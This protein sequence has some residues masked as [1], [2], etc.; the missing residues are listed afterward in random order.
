M[1]VPMRLKERQSINAY[2]AMKA[3]LSTAVHHRSSPAIDT[4]AIP[5]LGT[6]VG[7]MP[8][9]VSALQLATAYREIVLDEFGYP[10]EFGV[11][12]GFHRDLNPEIDLSKPLIFS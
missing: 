8:P 6:G 9:D 5:S 7:A 11:A 3:I 12:Q 4:I 2:L 1:R 10:G